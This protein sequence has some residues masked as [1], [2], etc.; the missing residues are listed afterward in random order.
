MKYQPEVQPATI[1][2]PSNAT[3]SDVISGF[4]N[5]GSDLETI[6]SRLLS[7][8][9]QMTGYVPSTGSA[10]SESEFVS[11]DIGVLR[12]LYQESYQKGSEIFDLTSVLY[13][14]SGAYEIDRNRVPDEDE[15]A[16]DEGKSEYFTKGN[17]YS[18]IS[19]FRHQTS[20]LRNMVRIVR[21][22]TSALAGNY[23]EETD[24]PF[25]AEKKEDCDLINVLYHI[26]G[27]QSSLT[28]RV[29]Y[30][31]D[32]IEMAIDLKPEFATEVMPE[33]DYSE[34]I[35]AIK[36]RDSQKHDHRDGFGK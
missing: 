19:A 18:A 5:V 31:L 34:L 25:P 6:K 4:S 28:N 10:D 9:L 20:R 33:D 35:S 27:E 15:C 22:I 13:H 12:H 14:S 30:A 29:F 11:G 21:E 16:E 2:N 24:C 1:A 36:Q 26:G 3:L 7:I 17:L 23:G 32:R 8:N